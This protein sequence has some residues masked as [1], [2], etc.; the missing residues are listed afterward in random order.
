[1][2]S[3]ESLE[4]QI[5]VLLHY[6]NTHH[7]AALQILK[8]ESLI[9]ERDAA[10]LE[11]IEAPSCQEMSSDSSNVSGSK[12]PHN[13]AKGCYSENGISDYGDDESCSS[14]KSCIEEDTN[15]SSFNKELS[16]DELKLK[17]E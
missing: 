13:E 16:I 14:D 6:F 12:I 9:I 10:K 17:E 1:M 2:K 15:P 11:Q 3:E 7:N 4:K 8:L 5:E